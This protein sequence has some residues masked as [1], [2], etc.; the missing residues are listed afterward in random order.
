MLIEKRIMMVLEGLQKT[1]SCPHEGKKTICSNWK[2]QIINPTNLWHNLI[3]NLSY[4]FE[5]GSHLQYACQLWAQQSQTSLKQ[6]QILQ[7]T[8]LKITYMKYHDC[9]NL[10][11]KEFCIFKF[12]D[13]IYL[14][15]FC[16]TNITKQATSCILPRIEILWQKPKLYDMIGSENITSYSN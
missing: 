16:A 1:S 8:A 4:H 6:I 13:L 7:N 14:K 11:Y 15:P 10:N 3:Y 12:K 9:A 5:D 2:W